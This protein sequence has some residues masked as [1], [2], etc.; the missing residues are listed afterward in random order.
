[1]DEPKISI[2][3]LMNEYKELISI[4]NYNY[5]NIEYPKDKLDWIIIDDSEENNIDLFPV[6][7]NVLYL[8]MNDSKEYLDKITFTS[9]KD[10]KDKVIHNYFLKTNTLPDG[11]K[12]DYGVGISSHEYI[13]HMDMGSIYHKKVIKRKLKFL[14]KNHLECV[15]CDSMLCYNNGK[16]YKIED[17]LR[18]YEE[19]LF[20]TKEFWKRSGFVWEDVCNEGDKFHYNNGNDRKM[21]VYYDTIKFINIHNFCNY[22]YK[23]VKIDGLD[24]FTPDFLK[25]LKIKEN[26][27]E[28]RLNKF[29]KGNF[30]VLGLNSNITDSFKD[31]ENIILEK[32]L[33]EKVILK[34]INDLNKNF[35][36]FIYNYNTEIWNIFKEVKFDIIIYETDK[37]YES[38]KNILEKNEYLFY[39]NIFI[40][41]KSLFN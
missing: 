29:F 34:K 5:N 12:R 30:N 2:V 11:F 31:S 18:A 4:F 14:K 32:K 3:V 33:K 27:I 1:M 21:D 9:E 16:I 20:H 26:N 23:E 40:H 17:N 8:H 39:E 28:F 10:K 25:D 41:K 38:M 6:S 19:T 37:N 35:N 7:E 24:I 22:K 13:F 15:Y 36:V